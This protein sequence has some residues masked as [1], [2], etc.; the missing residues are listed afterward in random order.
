MHARKSLRSFKVFKVYGTQSFRKYDRK[1]F[2]T[3]YEIITVLCN[4][5]IQGKDENHEQ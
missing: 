1:C 5:C 3:S 4:S 2:V